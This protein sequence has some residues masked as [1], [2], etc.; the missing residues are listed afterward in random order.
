[1]LY[2]F[3]EV[4]KYY[5]RMNVCFH[6]GLCSSSEGGNVFLPFV[7][8]SECAYVIQTLKKNQ[9]SHRLVNRS[10]LCGDIWPASES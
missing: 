2:F 4:P 3:V 1:M 5:R 8:V 10:D 9:C 7:G 6:F